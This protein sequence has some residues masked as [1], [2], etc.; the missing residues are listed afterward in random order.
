VPNACPA[1]LRRQF[2]DVLQK[3]VKIFP[4]EESRQNRKPFFFNRFVP[5]HFFH[6]TDDRNWK[7][8]TLRTTVEEWRFSAA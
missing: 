2:I 1:P 8:Q 7:M 3:S 4:Q 6:R 5:V